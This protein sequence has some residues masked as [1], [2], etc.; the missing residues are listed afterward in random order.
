MDC[1]A[2]NNGP[3][4]STTCSLPWVSPEYVFGGAQSWHAAADPRWQQPWQDLATQSHGHHTQIQE[5]SQR[6]RERGAGI[7]LREQDSTQGRRD[8]HLLSHDAP[9]P[10]P[11]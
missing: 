4:P 2:E 7:K 10:W 1:I 9:G 3:R 8:A 6:E 5:P 11:P